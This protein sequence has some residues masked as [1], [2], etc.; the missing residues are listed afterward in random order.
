MFAKGLDA[1]EDFIIGAEKRDGE[2]VYT[3]ERAAFLR[4]KRGDPA[5]KRVKNLGI[6]TLQVGGSKIVL[7]ED[8]LRL[9]KA[10]QCPQDL[11]FP[12]HAG[13][14]G[15]EGHQVLSTMLSAVLGKPAKADEPVVFTVHGAPIDGRADFSKTAGFWADLLAKLGY[16]PV[17]MNRA[18]A[19]LLGATSGKAPGHSA[20]IVL[21]NVAVDISVR[22]PEGALAFSLL[23]GSEWID[24]SVAKTKRVSVEQV[25]NRR[26]SGLD[27]RR[28]NVSDPLQGPLEIYIEHQIHYT[29][30]QLAAQI[31]KARISPKV[32]LTI[33]ISG[34]GA[35]IPGFSSKFEKGLKKVK[36]PFPVGRL[37][38]PSEPMQAAAGGALLRAIM[39]LPRSQRPPSRSAVKGA[40]A[41]GRISDAFRSA[42]Q[43]FISKQ[44]K[45]APGSAAAP[46]AG[47][48]SP[49]PPP[50]TSTEIAPQVVERL[51]RMES[52]IAE[53]E[54]KVLAEDPEYVEKMRAAAG[55]Q[56]AKARKAREKDFRPFFK[57]M[58]DKGGSDL[59]LSAGSR[60]AMRIDGAV[61]YVSGDPL[62]QEFC[63][64]LAEALSGKSY[65]DLFG[66]KM[67]VDLAIE[68]KDIGRFRA[69]IFHQRGKVGGVFR[70]IRETIPTF[71]ELNLPSRTMMKLAAHQRGMILVT[72]VAGSGKSTTLAGMIEH[73]NQSSNRH[74]VTIED[75]I[76]F[77]FKEKQSVIDQREVGLDTDNFMTALKSAVRQSPD[78]ILIGEMRDRETM[79][80][81]IS[82][83][84]TGHLVMSTLHTVNAQQTVERIITYSPPYQHNLIRMQL[85]MVLVGVLSVRLLPK[86]G[87]KGRVPAVEIMM[88]TPT[89]KDLLL[90]GKT[91]ELNSAVSEDVH[92]GNQTFNE[93]L[94]Q[95]YTTG[96]IDLEEA[97]SAADN[98]DELKLE[99]RGIQK[100]SRAADMHY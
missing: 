96:V 75:P 91:K 16:K 40:P 80:A 81:S 42:T 55:V 29:L 60:P 69:N 15:P 98:P 30:Q 51:R 61:R 97:L 33:V 6:Y 62:K 73:I 72:G 83:A 34:S 79:E 19:A 39:N 43:R 76:E 88:A 71:E 26:E 67:G 58:V 3:L 10:L 4:L 22:C 59:F 13:G 74:V 100:G 9:S 48:T 99:I 85:S 20:S 70:Y 49:P 21:G 32:P 47:R 7:G 37:L 5:E 64:A 41:P 56:E 25:R 66:D 89:I 86:K 18:E 92:F 31:L 35:R 27:L 2:V 45:G 82:A 11:A 50:P 28:P 8:A 77:V 17:P 23:R 54:D 78:V 63:I 14:P 68:L 36:L 12:F 93:S 1:G 90:T 24:N 52:R 65:K 53:I 94:K 87:G 84:E 38:L 95:L 57:L 44:G 46:P